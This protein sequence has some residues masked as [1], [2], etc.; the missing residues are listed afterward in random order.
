MKTHLLSAP[1]HLTT[2]IPALLL[3]FAGGCTAKKE[4]GKAAKSGIILEYRMAGPESFTYAV[5]GEA[6]QKLKINEMAMEIA[7]ISYQEYTFG[8]L[9]ANVDSLDEPGL[10]LWIVIDTM[11]LQIKTPMNVMNPSMENVIGKTLNMRLSPEGIETGPE[12]ARE[13]TY[14]IGPE[15]RNLGAEFQGF[16]PDFPVYLVKPGDKW[17]YPDTI[18]EESGANWLEISAM[19]NA[20]LDAWETVGN[21]RCARIVIGVSG[22]ITGKGHTQ[23]VDTESA[24]QYEGTDTVWFDYQKGILV[25]LV[26]TGKANTQTQTTG[27]RQMIIPS[28]RTM[29]KQVLLLEEKQ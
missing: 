12:K 11:S 29:K 18:R 19:N 23:G 25:K 2:W 16:F 28:E 3:I 5:T 22:K 10:P 17:N 9:P 7:L 4:A 26:S 15:I 8:Q 14:A 1:W 6:I 13:I 21:H 20:M 27:V 24:G